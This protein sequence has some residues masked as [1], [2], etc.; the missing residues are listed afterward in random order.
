MEIRNQPPKETDKPKVDSA[1][2]CPCDGLLTILSKEWDMRG[3]THIGMR[4][5]R[6]PEYTW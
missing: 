1:L 6:D 4:A 5:Q 2:I 3:M